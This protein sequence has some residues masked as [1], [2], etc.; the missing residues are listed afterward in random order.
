MRGKKRT[1]VAVITVLALALS[2]ALTAVHGEFMADLGMLD[3]YENCITVSWQEM[4]VPKDT[5]LPVYSAPYEDAWR[6]AKGKA[7]VSMKE[8]FRLLG[9]LDDGAWGLVD[10]KVDDK[11]R[12]IG[13]IRMPEGATRA[14]EYGDMYM[15]RTLLKVTKTVTLTDDPENASRKIRTIKAGEQVIGM[16]T[17]QAKG[18]IYV[19]TQHEGKTVWGFIPISA[20]TDISD[21]LIAKEGDTC[22]VA[23]GVTV[24]GEMYEYVPIE[25]TEDGETRWGSSVHIQPRD[26]QLR[27]V[28]L[29]DAN[30]HGIKYL[31]LPES[32]RWIGMEGICTGTLEEVRFG[33]NIRKAG[34]AFYSVRIRRLVLG[35]DY[36]GNIPDGDYLHVEEWAVEEG[37]PMYRDI[38]GVLFSADGKTLLRYPNG[39]KDEH[40]DVP[41]GT[42]EIGTHAF[43]DD[44]MEIALRSISLPIG[45]KRIGEYA[46][47]DCGYLL[48]MAIPLTVKELA[49]NAFANCVSL[50]R[51]SL[52]NGLTANLNDWV[53]HEDFTTSFRGD[54]W[55]TYPKPKEK[56]EWELESEETFR[57]YYVRLDNEEGQGTVT[58]YAA[59]TGSETKDPEK[60]GGPAEY[61]YEIQNG[62][63]NLGEDRWID[64]KNLR[65]DAGDIF[66][67]CTSAA[68]VNPEKWLKS[69]EM[70]MTFYN[71]WNGQAVFFVRNN[72]EY[73][74][75]ISMGL[76]EVILYR[77]KKG[78]GTAYGIIVP[79]GDSA[80]L[81][82][83]PGGTKVNHLYV[84]CQARVLEENGGWVKIETAYGTG[85]VSRSE[86]KIVEEEP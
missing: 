22:T 86:L 49:P 66:F 25:T 40:Y 12:R 63:A 26:I 8:K 32:L 30:M 15:N 74:D 1:A 60:A 75:D 42:E 36:T 77:E 35:K 5:K 59:P 10:Y 80:A 3:P 4:N 18:R 9:T 54:N 46:F 55:A 48:S 72:G 21:S 17:Y 29:W 20:V 51:L 50:E 70:E 11:S 43:T 57:A 83:T 6:G 53:Q 73:L 23:D 65:N 34:E 56:E 33:G 79:E 31:K 47:A 81:L 61:V 62:R 37:N 7:S 39:R 24:I 2:A 64:L 28:D 45:L 69:A 52:P 76:D 85:W 44:S 84:E 16:F 68:P 41:A 58:V 38:D 13:W 27:M 67:T 82:D 78:D 19:E 14:S 71:L